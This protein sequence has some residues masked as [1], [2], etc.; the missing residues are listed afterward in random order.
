MPRDDERSVRE[1]VRAFVLA[2]SALANPVPKLM[3]DL[4]APGERLREL[5]RNPPLATF[6]P[7]SALPI[8]IADY[9]GE[10]DHPPLEVTPS[11]ASWTGVSGGAED[12]SPT[13]SP[14]TP[15]PVF[16][17]R[18]SSATGTRAGRR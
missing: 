17:F 16:S 15:I 13:A 2:A 1:L 5:D 3:A 8:D 6:S 18:R 10:P 12:L 7:F 4:T 11:D 14:E 9:G